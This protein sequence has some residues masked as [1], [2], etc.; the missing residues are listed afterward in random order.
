MNIIFF[1]SSMEI[2]DEWKKRH[3]LEELKICFDSESLKTELELFPESLIIAD[4][5]SVASEINNLI[6]SDILPKNLL[7]LEKSPEV[8]TG[9]ML[10]SHGV[11]A[12]G[13]SRMHPNNFAQMIETVQKNKIWTYPELT[14]ALAKNKDKA[15]SDASMKLLNNRLT[16]KEIEV[17][18]LILKGMTNDAI[19]NALDITTRT[20]KAH[21]SSIFTKLHVNDRLS[22]V[23]LLK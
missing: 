2:M 22:L 3:Q 18:K 23:L 5:D 9:K 14:S 16:H 12:Y 21:I 1:S 6:L 7:V 17:V 10:I 4:Y 19:A 11:K 8:V 13:N 15:L 20:V